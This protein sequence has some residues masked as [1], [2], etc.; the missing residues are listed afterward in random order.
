MPRLLHNYEGA[1]VT[2]WK[3]ER[4]ISG[5]SLLVDPQRLNGFV[6][7]IYHEDWLC[8]VNHLRLGQ[9]AIGGKVRQL[10]YQVFANPER[11]VRGVRRYPCVWHAV[12]GSLAS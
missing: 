6:P 7:A 1:Q 12:A 10:H 11:S 8:I 9:V 5:G 3:Q 2:G 4:F